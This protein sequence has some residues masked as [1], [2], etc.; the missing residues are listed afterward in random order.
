MTD[1]AARWAT[2]QV[3]RH[4]RAVSEVADELGCDWHTVNDAVVTYGEALLGADTERVG[5]VEALGLDKTLFVRLGRFRSQHWCTSIVDVGAWHQV[6]NGPTEACNNLIMRI[7]RIGFGF[8]RFR[9]Y[10]VRALLYAGHPNWDLLAT[11]TP[12]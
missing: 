1:R 5:T 3:G 7:K 12:R 6:T 9:H 11:T 2:K 8:R 10:R 4:G